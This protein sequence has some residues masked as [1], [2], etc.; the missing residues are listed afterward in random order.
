MKY[1][2]ILQDYINAIVE[3]IKLFNMAAEQQEETNSTQS[4]DLNLE[5]R[6]VYNDFEFFTRYYSNLFI[7]SGSMGIDLYA[8]FKQDETA[9]PEIKFPSIVIAPFSSNIIKTN[10]RFF[11]PPRLY[12]LVKDKSGIAKKN[13]HVQGGVID[14][15]YTGEIR[16]ILYNASEYPVIIWKGDAIAQLVIMK[17]P[18]YRITRTVSLD[19]F[20]STERNESGFGELDWKRPSQERYENID[21]WKQI[22]LT[23][24][25]YQKIFDVFKNA[26]DISNAAS[27]R[28]DHMGL[29]GDLVWL[30]PGKVAVFDSKEHNEYRKRKRESETKNEISQPK[31]PKTD[32]KV[33]QPL[34]SFNEIINTESEPSESQPGPSKPSEPSVDLDEYTNEHEEPNYEQPKSSWRTWKEEKQ[35]RGEWIDDPEEYKRLMAEKGLEKRVF[36][37]PVTNQFFTKWVHKKKP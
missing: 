12:G 9:K 22:H 16:V 14:N 27:I 3:H 18:K 33:R 6:P 8:W 26:T 21:H 20:P 7:T 4:E 23:K 32:E 1:F 35:R 17:Y 11:F 37:N 31:K 25:E 24:P 36:K 5:V 10:V 29:L 30:E 2:I 13:L 19:P 15:D 28:N 34:P